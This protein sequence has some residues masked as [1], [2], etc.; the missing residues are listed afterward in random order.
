MIIPNVEKV[1]QENRESF[2]II[3]ENGVVYQNSEDFFSQLDKQFARAEEAFENCQGHQTCPP[4]QLFLNH[5]YKKS[6]RFFDSGIESKPILNRR[7]SNLHSA[8][9]VI[10]Q[11]I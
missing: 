3:S 6:L 9:T 1:F 4:D 2:L 8:T 10:Q 5:F 7:N 11:A